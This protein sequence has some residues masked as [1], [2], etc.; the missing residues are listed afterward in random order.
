MSKSSIKK[1]YD[2]KASNYIKDPT[3]KKFVEETVMTAPGQNLFYGKSFA[4]NEKLKYC[5]EVLGKDGPLIDLILRGTIPHMLVW[6]MGEETRNITRTAL[7]DFVD[8][9]ISQKSPS[10]KIV[11]DKWFQE[12]KFIRDYEDQFRNFR[13]EMLS[14]FLDTMISNPRNLVRILF[15]LSTNKT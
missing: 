12:T 7:K 6:N 10:L 9:H 15:S 8:E 4:R 5:I 13:N 14:S 1:E 11:L 3:L 2:L